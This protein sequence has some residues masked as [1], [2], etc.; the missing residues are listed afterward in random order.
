MAAAY[1]ALSSY[2]LVA[3]FSLYFISKNGFPLV[4]DKIMAKTFL[5]GLISI[6]VILLLKPV[7]ISFAAFS[8][9][10]VYF[11]LLLATRIFP[12]SELILVKVVAELVYSR[13]GSRRN[14]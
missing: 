5:A 10:A 8:G 4:L 12:A 6:I 1:M 13:G 2:T 9:I 11:L 14:G 3:F 7:S